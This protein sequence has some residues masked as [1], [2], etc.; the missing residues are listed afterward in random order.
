[1]ALPSD[2]LR[3]SEARRIAL[4]AQG[5]GDPRPS[6]R[7]DRRHFRRVVERVGLVQID[8][9]NVLT[10]SHELPFLAR[11][12]P[13][14]RAAL[15]AWLW[16]SGEI[17]EYWGHEA[18]LLPVE[19]HPLLRWR[20]ERDHQWGGVF[21]I[22]H[23]APELVQ[24]VYDAVLARGP[25]TLGQ[26]GDVLGAAVQRAPATP[27]NMWNWSPAKKAVEWLFWNGDVSATRN[28][29]SFERHY[30][31][32]DQ[33][34]PPA[35]LAQPTPTSDDAQ[36]ELLLLSA[37]SHGVGTARDLA[38][39]YRLNI[40]A[41]RRL[42]GELVDDGALRP[43]RV[44]GWSQPAFL[45]P[46]AVLPR[47][48]RA[49]ALLSPFDSL[50]WERSRTEALFGFRFRIEIYTPA[51]KRVHGYY[52]LPFL[53]DGAITARVDLKA[54]RASSTLL[55]RGSYGEPGIDVDRE[56]PVLAER[57]AELAGFLGLTAVRIEPR[58]DLAAALARTV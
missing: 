24:Q 23:G 56:V 5:F 37:R 25:V 55:V 50:I 22:G 48:V 47:W 42:L 17:F 44:E 19:R 38:D 15:S 2:A 7:V 10:R 6:G 26:L 43:V 28:P 54:D 53:N 45:H 30:V 20:M 35:V 57:L 3:L 32:P 41:A 34:I 8:S 21:G 12:G 39:Y 36:K 51:A 16:G 11:L 29:A 9:V 13:Y 46:E 14:P 1:M 40:P 33:V 18:S 49:S 4:H 31:A 58:G 52:V 27:G